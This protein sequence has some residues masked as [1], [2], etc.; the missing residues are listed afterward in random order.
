MFEVKNWIGLLCSFCLTVSYAQNQVNPQNVKIDA[1]YESIGVVWSITGDNNLNSQLVI[2]YKPTGTTNYLPTY[3]TMRANPNSIVDGNT[4]N[5]N[6]HAGSIVGLSENTSYDIRLVLSDV[7]GGT[8]TQLLSVLTKREVPTTYMGTSYYVIPGNGGGT[9]TFGDPYQGLQ[10]AA[11]NAAPG[12]IFEIGVGTYEP[13]VLTTSGTI[14]A[15]IVF[16]ALRSDS[17]I[18]DGNNTNTGIATL[19]VYNDSIQHIVFE[20]LI[21]QNGKWGI[22]AQNTQWVTVR[23]CIIRDVDYAY[24]NR[25]QNGWEHNQTI[26]DNFI[27]GRTSWPVNSGVIPPERGI[28]IRGN[29][30]VV[31]Y[32]LIRNFGDG[33]ST[34]GPPYLSSYALDIHN[35]DISY[36]GDDLIEVDGMIANTRVWLNRCSNGR[37]G[38]SVAPVFGGPCY[39][40]RNVFNNMELS[41]Y[42]MNRK[43]AGLIILHNSAAKEG[44][45]ITSD[46]GWHHTILKNNVLV[47]SHYCFEE[48]NLVSNSLIDDWDYNAYSSARSGL[49]GQPW[50]KWEGVQY[51]QLADLQTGTGQEMNGLQFDYTTDLTQITLPAQYSM[52]IDPT[53]FDF[54]PLSGSVLIDQGAVIDNINDLFVSDGSPDMGAHEYGSPLP[55]YGPRN[56]IHTVIEQ[57]EKEQEKMVTILRNGSDNIQILSE[58]L[59]TAVTLYTING[60]LLFESKMNAKT[61][62]L[63]LQE[64]TAGVYLVKI[65]SERQTEVMKVV[66]Q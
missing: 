44:R 10:M 32:N 49:S 36:I 6:H 8:S 58:E 5:F 64:L 4:L 23:N 21:V 42:K 47:S 63:N 48:Y 55:H 16:T 11:D 61:A 13:F 9:G 59:I 41:T 1:T 57:V 65:K 29:C 31:R 15:P 35:N 54:R 12:A 2:E 30:N 18:I 56:S 7:D 40:Y 37:M 3:Q 27:Y 22:D 24:V 28:D 19:G 34:D 17:V 46:I 45:G 66:K 33:I 50:F 38:V 25:R 52:G 20:N 53:I 26:S 62:E 14:N 51:L 60:Q 43:S 39:V